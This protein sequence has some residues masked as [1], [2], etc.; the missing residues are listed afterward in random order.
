MDGAWSEKEP[1]KI[2]MSWLWGRGQ[3]YNHGGQK[4]HTTIKTTRRCGR[5]TVRERAAPRSQGCPRNS[6][7]T[8]NRYVKS[9]QI[10]PLCPGQSTSSAFLSHHNPINTS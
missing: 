4:L 9:L 6:L 7:D 8:R 2:E 3:E 5:I 1:L 10:L